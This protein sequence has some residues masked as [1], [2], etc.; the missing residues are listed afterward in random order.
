ME[1]SCSLDLPPY[2]KLLVPSASRNGEAS[3]S[4]VITGPNPSNICPLPHLHWLPYRY[5]TRS[6]E[7]A[8]SPA[9]Y[10]LISK[11]LIAPEV[12]LGVAEG[13][14]VAV[15][16]LE[17]VIVAEV[18]VG[19]T[20]EVTDVVIVALD[21]LVEVETTTTVLLFDGFEDVYLYD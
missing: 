15:E 4:N 2:I 16:A 18:V 8:A 20:V 19:L 21:A 14:G 17:D 1:R 10:L 11:V 12:V 7:R 5:A 13:V 6:P 3:S 9:T